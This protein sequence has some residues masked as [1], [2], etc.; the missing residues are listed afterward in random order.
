MV[1]TNERIV[2]IESFMHTKAVDGFNDVENSLDQTSR[3]L[4][5]L[6]VLTAE[7][8]RLLNKAGLRRTLKVSMKELPNVPEPVIDEIR[9]KR[10][11]K[12]DSKRFS[13]NSKRD[14]VNSK[15]DSLNSDFLGLDHQEILGHRLTPL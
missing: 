13:V 14:S 3:N 5:E 10:N 9:P 12:R 7:F 8:L 6:Q 2:S 11:F 4:V 1:R 15:R